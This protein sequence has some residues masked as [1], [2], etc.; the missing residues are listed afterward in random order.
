[1]KLLLALL[2]F[3]LIA[4]CGL[5]KEVSKTIAI[6]VASPE[7]FDPDLPTLKYA[8]KDVDRLKHALTKVGGLTPQQVYTLGDP[9]ID[10]LK[11]LIK[12][13]LYD[14]AKKASLISPEDTKLIFY[15]TG[16]SD[17]NGLHFFDRMLTRAELH[18]ILDSFAVKTKVI[19]LDSCYSGA[20]AEKGIKPAEPFTIPKADF[21]EPHGTVFMTAS[22]GSELAFEID[23]I[24]G[25]LFTHHI[26]KGL[27][28]L[29][30]LNRDGFVTIDELYQFV[31]KNMRL[32]ALTLPQGVTQSPEFNANLKG[33]GALV[34]AAPHQKQAQITLGSGIVGT[35]TFNNEQGIQIYQLTKLE[36]LAK[37]ITLIAGEYQVFL[38]TG[39]RIG[40]SKLVLKA[41]DS[42]VLSKEDFAY[43]TQIGYHLME[44]GRRDDW[45]LGY[46]GG[47]VASSFTDPGPHLELR[48]ESPGIYWNLYHLRLFFGGTVA[49]NKLYYQGSTGESTGAS[50]II[51]IKHGQLVDWGIPGQGIHFS[52]IGGIEYRNQEWKDAGFLAFDP[53]MPK[54]GGELSTSIIAGESASYGFG[55]RREWLFVQ[56]KE[57]EDTLAFAAT[58]FLVSFFF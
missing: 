12:T 32:Q 34:L 49:K 47:V 42:K 7:S 28:G 9:T 58:T 43:D 57:S 40:T 8:S 22:S 46:A 26:V 1:M 45:V 39:G 19:I 20:L 55:I 51:G 23:E 52:L 53:Q 35:I 15:Y 2:A 27:Y 48:Y 29:A 6:L 17:I 50:A 54:F 18:E 44:K 31:Y 13:V 36:P 10:S 21:D 56:K 25:S 24:E 41:A 38:H 4:P 30:D 16:H 37:Q 11:K 5:S 33:K 14:S 3:C